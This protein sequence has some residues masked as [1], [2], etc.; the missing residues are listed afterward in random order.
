MSLRRLSIV[1]LAVAGLFAAQQGWYPHEG[2]MLKY[3]VKIRFGEEPDTMPDGWKFGRVSSVAAE[4]KGEVYVFHRGP[5]ANPIVVFD[6]DGKY[7]RSWGKGLFGNPH[8]MRVDKAGFVWVTDN[9]DHQVMKF[10]RDGEL[11]MKLG[12]KGKAGTDDKTF[13]RPTDIA[14]ASNGDFYVSDGYGNSRV[15]KFSKDGRFLKAWGSRGTAQGQFNTPHSVAV[16]KQDSAYVAE[17]ENLPIP[18]FTPGGGV[19]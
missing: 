2:G 13:N 8:G 19:L 4:S 14:F 7:L 18:R 16:D 17:P 1:L 6:H 5:K 11:L 12:I 3:R 15:V 10:T 9:G